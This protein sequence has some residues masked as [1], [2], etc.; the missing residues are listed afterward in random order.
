MFPSFRTPAIWASS[1]T[2][3]N[4]SFSSK[5]KVLRKVAKVSWSGCKLPAIKRNGTLS[6]VARSILRVLNTPVA[7]AIEQQAQQDFGCVGLPTARS[8]PR[9]DGR[10]VELG[11][12]V[13]HEACQVIRRQAVAKPY[14]HVQ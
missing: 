14:G 9:V 2:C 13:H 12:R 8:V 7:D 5:R 4:S 10:Q 11:D 6:N 1:S 3:T